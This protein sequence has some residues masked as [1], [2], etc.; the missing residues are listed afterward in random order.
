MN[1][2]LHSDVMTKKDLREVNHQIYLFV[3]HYLLGNKHK[4]NYIIDSSLEKVYGSYE[5][6]G[7]LDKLKELEDYAKTH[8]ED[9]KWEDADFKY[10]ISTSAGKAT[11]DKATFSIENPTI[12]IMKYYKEGT[13]FRTIRCT[14]KKK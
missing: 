3:C 8:Y 1:V 6:E 12:D 13:P 11:F 10:S 5:L 7:F 4:G 9:S 14:A 2:N